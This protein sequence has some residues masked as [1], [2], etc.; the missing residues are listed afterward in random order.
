MTNP[1]CTHGCYLRLLAFCKGDS[2]EGFGC[3]MDQERKVIRHMT[4]TALGEGCRLYEK[5][6][7][8]LLA[9]CHWQPGR[10][11]TGKLLLNDIKTCWFCWDDRSNA[12]PGL[13]SMT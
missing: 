3:K 12:V 6:L 13:M 1:T 4:A 8:A 5:L 7:S 9:E 2:T 11:G 10:L